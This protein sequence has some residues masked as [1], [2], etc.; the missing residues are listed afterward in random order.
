MGSAA[1]TRFAFIAH[2]L[3]GDGPFRPSIGYDAEGRATSIGSTYLI[4]YPR[5]SEAKF[6]R[7]NELAFYASPLA[8][9]AS[10]FTGYLSTRGPSRE[11]PH[12]LYKAVADDADGKGSAIDAFWLQFMQNAKARGSMCLLVDMPKVEA[13]N[14]AE[15]IRSRNA[16]VWTAIAP[17]LLTEYEIGDDGRFTFA[18]FSGFFTDS[19]GK[20]I[21]CTWHFDTAEWRATDREKKV[22][23]EGTHPLGDC[24]LLI[25][26]EGGDFPHFGPFAALADLSKRL[27]NL[28]S[29]LDEILRAQTF[30]LLTMQVPDESTAQQRIEAARAAGET[31]GTNNLMVHSGSTPAFI[32]PP[33]GPARIYLD[34]IA[35]LRQQIDEIGLNVATPNAR[36]SGI[37]LQ[38]R[39]QSINAELSRFANRMEDLERN[40]WD[41]SRR[42]LQMTTAPVVQWPRDYSLLDVQQELDILAEMIANG[43][44]D[45][46]IAEQRKR[47]VS[48]QFI[49]LDQATQDK[50][51]AAIDAIAHE[52]PPGDNVIP[53]RPDPNADLRAAAVRA[54]N[55]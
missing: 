23:A 51:L 2:A 38:M 43:M 3:N 25:F 20:R 1:A 17:E 53:L 31:I 11:I 30:S 35:A 9:A 42:W 46:A 12:P 52:T 27:F 29:E 36:E 19:S 10:R 55:G 24:P 13:G 8:Q 22:L 7:R 18:E 50:V 28:D 32:A 26:T 16:P 34:R 40:A 21:E 14:M 49:G 44:P 37:A 45:E 4:Q 15:Q 41:L 33:D 6:A 48:Q 47:I 54:L 5:E 39:F